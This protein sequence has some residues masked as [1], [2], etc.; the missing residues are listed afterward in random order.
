MIETNEWVLYN[1][2]S[3]MFCMCI[4]SLEFFSFIYW[5]LPIRI[6]YD[7]LACACSNTEREKN[8]VLLN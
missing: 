5:Q 4:P 2:N 3:N 8:Y 7:K 6:S 1:K